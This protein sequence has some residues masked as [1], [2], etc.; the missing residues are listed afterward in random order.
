MS[1]RRGFA[2]I[3]A[4]WLLVAFAAIGTAISV[5]ARARRLSTAN[6]LDDERGVAAAQAGLDHVRSRL[7]RLIAPGAVTHPSADPG[8]PWRDATMILTD[9][10]RFRDELYHVSI[11]DAGASLNLNLAGEQQIRRMLI[12]LPIDAGLATEI[13]ESVADWRDSDDLHHLHGAEA[14]EYLRTGSPVLPSNADFSRI[15]DFAYVKGVTPDIYRRVRPLLTIV[16]TGQIN[17]NSAPRPVLLSLPGMTDEAV[18]VLERMRSGPVSIHSLQELS[19][20]LSSGPRAAL[21]AA[22]PEI[23]PLVAFETRELDVQSEGWSEGSP[24]HKGIE[25]LV[26]KAGR[27]GVV[28]FRKMT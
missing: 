12:A 9:T 14:D 10:V 28:T 7:A 19:Q 6:S 24:V 4:L 1:P 22:I 3:A 2:L 20:Q 8:D 25:A 27:I 26:V 16:G 21:T 23:M 13:A 15:E 17:L 11:R 5:Q 18:A